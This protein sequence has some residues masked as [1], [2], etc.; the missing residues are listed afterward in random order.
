MLDI[1][2]SLIDE[3]GPVTPEIRSILLQQFED[4]RMV[5]PRVALILFFC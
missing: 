1:L 3:A 5:R 2:T 4:D